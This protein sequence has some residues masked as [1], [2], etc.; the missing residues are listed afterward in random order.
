MI[1]IILISIICI[2]QWTKIFEQTFDVG[3]GFKYK[4]NL[5]EDI[6]VRIDKNPI[7]CAYCLSFWIGVILSTIYL[8]A[9]YMAIYMYYLIKE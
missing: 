2:Y 5:I 8:D 3:E 9:S 1:G 4:W 6:L 7:N